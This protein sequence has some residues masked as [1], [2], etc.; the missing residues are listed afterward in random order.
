MQSNEWF[1]LPISYLIII[2]EGKNLK[3]FFQL[4][5]LERDSFNTDF[6]PLNQTNTNLAS[7]I[8]W[9]LKKIMKK[10]PVFKMISQFILFHITIQIMY[11]LL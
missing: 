2:A 7:V 9:E 3:T 4:Q 11:L 8:E 10:P 5:I 1:N 6:T